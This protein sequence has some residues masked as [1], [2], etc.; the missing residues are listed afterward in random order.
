MNDLRYKLYECKN[1]YGVW[2]TFVLQWFRNGYRLNRFKL[3]RLQYQIGDCP[4]DSYKGIV[5]KGDPIYYIHIPSSGPLNYEDVCES[6]K[7]A[8]GFYKDSLI[9][10]KLV[11]FCESWLLYEPLFKDYNDKSN[12]K[13]F[14]NL[15]HIVKNID[16]PENND[17]WRVFNVDYSP[18][19]INTVVAD[20]SL[21]TTV[22]NHL[23]N[24]GT[25]GEGLGVLIIDKDFLK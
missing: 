2:G 16:D 10:G 6:L 4:I 7:M 23:K 3:G 13:K 15:F 24:G 25:M 5:K 18:Q 21:K 9:D 11:L 1:M 19:I 8:Y 17:F 22:I 14:F 20:N 12:I